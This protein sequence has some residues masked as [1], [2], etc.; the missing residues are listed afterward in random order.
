MSA[1]T[2]IVM[3]TDTLLPGFELVEVFGLVETT[4][5]K[6]L[7]KELSK[8]LLNG[9]GTSFR[10]PSIISAGQ[11]RPRLMLSLGSEC[12]PPSSAPQTE[13]HCSS[14]ITARL[15]DAIFILTC[16]FLTYSVHETLAATPIPAW[17]GIVTMRF[18]SAG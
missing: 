10:R 8:G 17:L 9:I 13:T 3:T 7:Q 1:D 14:R 5:T 18:G 2:I 15:H 11:L 6:Q 4:Y 12:R 16:S